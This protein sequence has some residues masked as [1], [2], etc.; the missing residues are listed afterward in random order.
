[1]VTKVKGRP[2]FFVIITKLL[3]NNCPTSAW[4]MNNQR[5]RT[6]TSK[7]VLKPRPSV[8]F[9]FFFLDIRKVGYDVGSVV[10]STW[11]TTAHSCYTCGLENTRGR[12]GSRF[13]C[14]HAW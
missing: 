8:C 13:T 1:M 9:P 4:Y 12:V 7:N 5:L 2:Y 3:K 6:K 11:T 14:A 10:E